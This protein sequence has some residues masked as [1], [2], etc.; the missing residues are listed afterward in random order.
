[1]GGLHQGVQLNAAAAAF[2]ASQ[3]AR[4]ARRVLALGALRCQQRVQACGARRAAAT[5]L[6]REHLGVRPARRDERLR[7]ARAACGAQAQ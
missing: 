3:S 4:E 6:G 7:A 5:L 1:M 2:Q